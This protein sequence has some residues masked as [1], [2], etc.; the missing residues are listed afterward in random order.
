M[1]CP[2]LARGLTACTRGVLRGV[3]PPT[4]GVW[5]L[6]RSHSPRHQG[7]PR[8]VRSRSSVTCSPRWTRA[9][10]QLPSP[11]RGSGSGRSPNRPRTR[12]RRPR[13]R[14]RPRRGLP[15]CGEQRERVGDVDTNGLGRDAGE[16]ARRALDRASGALTAADVT[17]ATGLARPT[18]STTLSRL[19]KSGEVTKA[20]RGAS[21]PQRE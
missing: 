1:L 8:P 2:A 15:P 5:P 18:V 7:A 16:G 21:G 9:G 10:V 14:G 11:S 4:P 17:K 13:R 12:R 20:D 19:G 6:D 3:G